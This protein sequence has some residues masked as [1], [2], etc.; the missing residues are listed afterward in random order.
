MLKPNLPEGRLR[1]TSDAA[2][3]AFSTRLLSKG[4][5]R[6]TLLALRLRLDALGWLLGEALLRRALGQATIVAL[7][8]ELGLLGGIE[9]LLVRHVYSW[10][11]REMYR[12][13]EWSLIRC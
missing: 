1:I 7:G 10:R 6:A 5:R 11:T 8:G 2:R 3:T 9:L 4:G 13:E 12:R